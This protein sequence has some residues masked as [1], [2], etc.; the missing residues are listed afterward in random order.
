MML[1]TTYLPLAKEASK[2]NRINEINC[3]KTYS[4]SILLTY[5]QCCIT[6]K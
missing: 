6:V 1:A 5:L 4:L 2:V 3:I